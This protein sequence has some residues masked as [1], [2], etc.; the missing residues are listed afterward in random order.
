[1]KSEAKMAQRIKEISGVDT[2]KCMKCGRC[3]AS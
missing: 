1:M 2:R 3:S